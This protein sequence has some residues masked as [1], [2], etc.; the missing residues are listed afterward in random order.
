MARGWNL[1]VWLECIG[2]VIIIMTFPFSTCISYFFPAASLFLCSYLMFFVLVY[3]LASAGEPLLTRSTR[4]LSVYIIIYIVHS[5]FL[6]PQ[7]PRATRKR[8]Q[9]V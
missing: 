1:W 6:V 8:K 9:A 7:S 2:V 3:L 5:S 4:P